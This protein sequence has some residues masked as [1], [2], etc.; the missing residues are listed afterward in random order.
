MLHRRGRAQVSF[1]ALALLA[2][3]VTIFGDPLYAADDPL[4]TVASQQPSEPT[5]DTE[6][7][8]PWSEITEGDAASSTDHIVRIDQRP[9]GEPMDMGDGD[10]GWTWQWV[11]AG[12]IYHSYMAGP[13]EPRAALM[14]FWDGGDRA[15]AD[16]TLGGRVGFVKFG[17]CDPV[18]S[19]GWQLDFYGAAISRLDLKNKEDLNSCDYVFGFPITYGDEVWQ[20]KF[21][22]AHQ[23]SHLGDEFSISHPGVDRVN[24]VRDSL[25]W[26]TSYYPNPAWRVYGEAAWCFHPDGGAGPWETQFGTELSRPGP[27]GDHATPFVAVNGRVREDEEVVGDVNFQAGWLHRGIL[28]QTLRYGFDYYHGKSSQSQFFRDSEQQFGMGVWYDF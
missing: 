7:A 17:N 24:Y 21:G 18:H 8:E 6:A 4:M 16:A 13:L 2:A 1:Y 22:Y 3:A 15:F 20:F 12:L 25:E 19:A 11:P 10:D 5:P 9:M 23:S 26:G 27:T 14:P 28:G